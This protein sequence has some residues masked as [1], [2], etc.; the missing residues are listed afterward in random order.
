MMRGKTWIIEGSSSSENRKALGRLVH[1]VY[2]K[3]LHDKSKGCAWLLFKDELAILSG[4]RSD[5]HIPVRSSGLDYSLAKARGKKWEAHY[6]KGEIHPFKASPALS[7]RNLIEI[8]DRWPNPPQQLK[9][10]GRP[11]FN[12][13]DLQVDETSHVYLVELLSFDPSAAGVRYYK[14][15]KAKSIP[16]RIRQFGPCILVDSIPFSSERD[17]YQAEADLHRRFECFRRT[18]TEIFGLDSMSLD[19]LLSVFATFKQLE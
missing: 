7:K 17:S 1:C 14:I 13:S 16:K 8:I 11:S 3:D 15:G 9:P 19:N 10:E 5:A 18:G 6:P 12:V 2:W 4:T